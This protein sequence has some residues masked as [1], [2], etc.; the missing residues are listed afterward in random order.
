MDKSHEKLVKGPLAL[1]EQ[2]RL[3]IVE[4]IKERNIQP[5]EPVPSEGELADLFGVSRRTGK[6]AL[7]LLAEQGVVY[8]LP[9]RGTFLSEAG[10]GGQAS[11]H[12]RPKRKPT[13]AMIVPELNEYIGQ[14]VGACLNAALSSGYELV[15]RISG[16]DIHAEEE[17][18]KEVASARGSAGII[19]FPGDRRVCGDQVMRLHLEGFPIVIVDRTFRETNVPSVYHDH[20]QGAYDMTRYLLERGHER[21]G[22]V[23]EAVFGVMSREDRYQG[24]VQ[25]LMEQGISIYTKSIYTECTWSPEEGH[26]RKLMEDLKVYLNDNAEMTAIVCSNDL[27]AAQV[28][29]ATTNLGIIVPD[30]LSVV[31]FTD[32]SIARM[33]E[34]PLTTVRKPTQPL[35]EHAVELLMERILDPGAAPRFVK[36]ATQIMER[37]SVMDLRTVNAVSGT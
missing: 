14:V 18:L 20:Y 15:L 13:I 2:M 22:F 3:K 10:L 8:R 29:Y 16:G 31:G 6:E 33:I 5:H 35:G 23:S 36:L 11:G 1:Y 21:I 26:N 24:Y 4:L 17:A 27:V 19:L 25:A 7:K 12:N 34:T 28:L 32:L 9:R 37:S 30:R